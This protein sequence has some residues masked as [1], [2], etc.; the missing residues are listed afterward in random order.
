MPHP[1]HSYPALIR[2]ILENL[3]ENAVFFCGTNMPSIQ[4]QMVELDESEVKIEVRDN[5]QGIAP[6]LQNR[7]FDM[8]FRGNERSKGN[9]LGLYIVKKAVEKLNGRIEMESALHEGTT[10]HVFLPNQPMA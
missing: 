7:V 1:F 10:F 9:G 2:I 6:E 5:G 8:Y 3:I 4:V